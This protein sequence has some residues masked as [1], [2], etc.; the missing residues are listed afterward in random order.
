MGAFSPGVDREASGAG[1]K[2]RDLRGEVRR[3]DAWGAWRVVQAF[4][5]QIEEEGSGDGQA[6]ARVVLGAFGAFEPAKDGGSDD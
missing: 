3:L 5:E 1:W 6:L 4:L 2:Q